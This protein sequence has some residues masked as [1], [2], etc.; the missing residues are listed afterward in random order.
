MEYSWNIVVE[1]QKGV[2]MV[3]VSELPPINTPITV[4]DGMDPY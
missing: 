2:I 1:G 4:I 3:R